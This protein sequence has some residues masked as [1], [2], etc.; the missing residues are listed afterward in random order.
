MT[1]GQQ[2]EPGN[3]FPETSTVQGRQ[4]QQEKPSPSD[5]A[6]DRWCPV[7]VWSDQCQEELSHRRKLWA[8]AA[9][10][11]AGQRQ[12]RQSVDRFTTWTWTAL[13][14]GGAEAWAGVGAWRAWSSFRATSSVLPSSVCLSPVY[15]LSPLCRLFLKHRPLPPTT[16]S[17]CP[18]CSPLSTPK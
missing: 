8:P 17:L 5:S 4:P 16:G 1:A 15:H 12:R 14:A 11:G 10:A 2:M 18:V 9:A 3:A 6:A 7:K 13:G